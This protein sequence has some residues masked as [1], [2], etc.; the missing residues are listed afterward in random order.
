MAGLTD[1]YNAGPG[2]IQ[3]WLAGHTFLPLETQRYVRIVTGHSAEEWSQHDI[4]ESSRPLQVIPCNAIAK[5]IAQSSERAR[6][7]VLLPE[8]RAAQPRDLGA[9]N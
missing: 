2:R 9:C 1:A 8:L 7:A 6:V 4:I 3:R 5:L